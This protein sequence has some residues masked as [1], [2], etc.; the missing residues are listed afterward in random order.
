MNDT[1]REKQ[2]TRAGA[3]RPSVSGDSP[4]ANSVGAAYG[5]QV[6]QR[7]VSAAHHG[8]VT[9]PDGEGAGGS[10]QCGSLITLQIQVKGRLIRAARYRAYGC[11]ATLAC[12]DALCEMV[13]GLP[14]LEAASISEESL[15]ALLGLE[16]EKQ[17]TAA[18]ALDALQAALGMVLHRQLQNELDTAVI[19]DTEE[20]G[21]L[22]GMSGGV[23]SGYAAY[24][25]REAGFHVVGLTLR[26]WNSGA[27]GG[28][29]TCC[30][31][32]AAR[33][34]RTTAHSLGLPH[35]VLD[36]SQPFHDTV[37]R[38]FIREYAAGRTPNPCAKCNARLRF[39]LLAQAARALG[40]KH[41]ATG[42]Y[43]RLTGTA[44]CLTRG[45]DT[46]K[47]Q[48]YVLAEVEPALL[49]KFLFPL[50]ELTKKTVRAQAAAIGLKGYATVE[51]QEVCFVPDEDYK[52]FLR[53]QLG[54]LPGEVVDAEGRVV[55]YHTGTYNFTIGQRR[56]VGVAACHP[57]YVT[58]ID[59][60]SRRVTVGPRVDTAVNVLWLDSLVFHEPDEQGPLTVQVRSAGPP[61]PVDAITTQGEAVRVVLGHP[62]YGVAPGQ[63]GVVYRGSQVALAGTITAT[64][65]H[66]PGEPTARGR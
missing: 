57:L 48:S 62:A 31:L 4:A 66:H 51:S 65:R 19:E 32:A 5:R 28:E 56:G 59:S 44:S 36:A 1:A 2:E 34:A 7:V 40:L 43:A 37:V 33:Q 3:S 21:V 39:G 30:S 49:S 42:H 27:E 26:L 60:H 41:A 47:D 25:L 54:E 23:D 18:I 50:G 20:R 9:R 29:R 11:P 6:A 10:L 8:S 15:S 58:A 52:R 38:Y 46:R 14:L 22:L 24:L 61:L 45:V 53:E 13:E 16:P 35:L 64:E 55:G 12:A 63:T 17:Y